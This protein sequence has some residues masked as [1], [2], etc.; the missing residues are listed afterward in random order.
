MYTVLMTQTVSIRL[1]DRDRATLAALA[2]AR[3]VKGI[4]ALVRDLAEREAEAARV[5][6][7][8]QQVDGFMQDVRGDSALASEVA[9]LS[10]IQAEPIDGEAWWPAQ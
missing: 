7:I 1:T 5:A 2:T 6:D 8:R 10:E 4:S 3:G 9:A